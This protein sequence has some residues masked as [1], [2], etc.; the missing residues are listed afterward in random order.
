MKKNGE[1][2][3][4]HVGSNLLC[5]QHIHSHYE[6]YQEWC[7]KEEIREHHHSVPQAL[8]KQR[9]AVRAKG[10]QQNLDGI[11]QKLSRMKEFLRKNVLHAVAKFVICDDQVRDSIDRNI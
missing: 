5:C 2:K 9:D 3:V 1:R 10:D 8:V 11:I 4:F 7:L 6:L